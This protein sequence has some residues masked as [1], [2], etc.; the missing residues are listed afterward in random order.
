MS[1]SE[2]KEGRDRKQYTANLALA[3]VASQVGCVTIVIVAI[4]LILGLWLDNRFDTSPIFL[5]TITIAS[6]PVTVIIMLWIV[7]SV[8]ARIKPS[9]GDKENSQE[10]TNRGT[11]TKQT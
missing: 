2:H 8:T 7:R 5:A 1:Q 4:S 11:D 10:E 3:A 6:V 9:E